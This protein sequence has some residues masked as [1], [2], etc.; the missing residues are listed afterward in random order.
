MYIGQKR[1]R[2]KNPPRTDRRLGKFR[3]EKEL[4]PNFG[5]M[6]G[7]DLAGIL[8]LEFQ[9]WLEDMPELRSLPQEVRKPLVWAARSGF[10]FGVGKMTRLVETQHRFGGKASWTEMCDEL[11]ELIPSP[12]ELSAQMGESS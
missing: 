7:G 2:K 10:F 3:I 9:A 11:Y 5:E 4:D 12:A 1:R 8:A 6:C